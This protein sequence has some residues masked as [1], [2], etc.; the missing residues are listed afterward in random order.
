MKVLIFEDD[1][2]L[3]DMYVTKYKQC[4][5][6]VVAY[7]DPSLDPVSIVLKE[8]PDII[9]MDVVMPIMNGFE[10]LERIKQDERTKHIPVIL[11][12]NLGQK[13]DI[14]KG[15]ALGATE[16]MIKTNFMPGQVVNRFRKALGFAP[17]AEYATKPTPAVAKEAVT[18]PKAMH[19]EIAALHA[20][21]ARVEADKAWETSWVRQG[22]IAAVT[23][24]FSVLF[25][26]AANND[27]PWLYGF[28]PVMGYVLSTLSLPSLKKWWM[29]GKGE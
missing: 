26:Y 6:D 21:N 20:R 2:L 5:I 18:Q 13:E 22:F 4:G 1:P 10:A 7:G 19:P 12:T 11:L 14:E 16:Y 17:V 23:Y 3:Q 8:K 25:M 28:V 15:M 24:V 29:K 27:Q 9:S